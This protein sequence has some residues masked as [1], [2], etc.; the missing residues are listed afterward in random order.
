M[1][2]QLEKETV[3]SWCEEPNYRAPL[4]ATGPGVLSQH[5]N[6]DTN[7]ERF[8]ATG[9][10]SR[11]TIV[12]SVLT[13][14]SDAGYCMLVVRCV[15]ATNAENVGI[16][17]LGIQF[18]DGSNTITLAGDGFP[19]ATSSGDQF[20]SADFDSRVID[21]NGGLT[22]AVI[23]S[24]R[25]AVSTEA[26][27]FWNGY[28]L[29]ADTADN[30]PRGTPVL[31][32]DFT[33]ATGTFTC[34]I[35]ASV[36]GDTWWLESFCKL[37]G[38][39]DVNWIDEDIERP[40]QR[41]DCGEEQ[42]V[43]GARAWSATWVLPLKG[44]GTAAS[45]GTVGVFPQE[46]KPGLRS[47]FTQ[48]TS[49]GDTVV[50]ASGTAPA[51][52]TTSFN[53]ATGQ[54]TRFPVGSIVMD[55]AGRTAVVTATAANGGDPDSVTIR[56]ALNRT[57]I[58]AEAIYGGA[59]YEPQVTG[60]KTIRLHAFGKE[61]ERIGF[62]GVSNAKFVGFARNDVPRVEFGYQGGY[63]LDL[64]RGKASPM[65]A[66]FDTIIPKSA[67]DCYALLVA[68]GSNTVTRLVVESC[69]IDTGHELTIEPAFSLFDALFGARITNNKCRINLTLSGLERTSPNDT[70][71]E[72]ERYYA[73]RV[74]S[75]LIQHGQ[76]RGKT[77]SFY[78]HRCSWMNPEEPTE[79]GVNKLQFTAK[80]LGSELTNMPKWLLGF[81]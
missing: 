39:P 75:L 33:A 60:H 77:V 52:S 4:R 14:A 81:N 55:S 3:Y 11:T 32:A 67:A 10:G 16:S 26:D 76:A 21:T 65:I 22:N 46:T 63:W 40:V 73:S 69:E 54:L 2:T 30:N 42:D 24:A 68:E 80:V 29:V 25:A 34:T 53:V 43:R 12:S 41:G 23:T 36:I 7:A 71:A 49:T 51:L 18:A 9:A 8:T 44:S 38:P 27:D 74:F 79:N 59:S 56:P 13:V 35:A 1:T 70:Y 48:K 64:R 78:A 58:A 20:E 17:C 15:A 66:Q 50:A 47:M 5:S 61:I 72:K 45:A 62:G 37:W 28:Y 31:V 57:P 19:A 6:F